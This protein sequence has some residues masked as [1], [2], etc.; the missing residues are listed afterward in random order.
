MTTDF[1]IA[2]AELELIASEIRQIDSAVEKL[3]GQN[4]GIDVDI[5][6]TYD[7]DKPECRVYLGDAP[8]FVPVLV[9]ALTEYRTSRECDFEAARKM[10]AA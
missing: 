7:H 8:S 2:A 4:D 9:K 5:R 10:L 3:R 1:L 6:C